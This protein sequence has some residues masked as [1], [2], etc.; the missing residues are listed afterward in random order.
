MP[1]QSQPK[2]AATPGIPPPRVNAAGKSELW[3]AASVG[4]VAKV[5]SLLAAPGGSLLVNLQAKDGASPLFAACMYGHTE[6]VCA[7]LSGGAKVDLLIKE[8]GSP[9]HAACHSGHMGAVLA[10]LSAGAKVNLQTTAGMTPLHAACYCGHMEVA[11]A[12][13]SGGPRSTWSPPMVIHPCIR[14]AIGAT[15]R[16]SATCYLLGP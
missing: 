6:V 13:L 2:P 15:R 10:L 16:W 8:L 14:Y 5:R 12:L 7:L 1:P 3:I 11:R 4:D 9:L